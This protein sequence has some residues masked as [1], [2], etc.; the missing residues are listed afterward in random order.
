MRFPVKKPGA[1]CSSS[2]KKKINVGTA[3]LVCASLVGEVGTQVEGEGEGVAGRRSVS[4]DSE[5][6]LS[7]FPSQHRSGHDAIVPSLSLNTAYCV[8]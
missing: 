3:R 4:S 7:P 2:G 6:S 8:S 1:R 5:K